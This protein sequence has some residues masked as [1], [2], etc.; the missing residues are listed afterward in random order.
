MEDLSSTNFHGEPD[1]QGDLGNEDGG[2]TQGE[3]EVP[4]L[5]TEGVHTQQRTH[6]AAQE[7]RADQGPLGDAPAIFPGFLLVDEH[8]K[9]CGGID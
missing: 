3:F 8:K 7:R 5:M 1:G 2:D 6:A 4:G 9:E